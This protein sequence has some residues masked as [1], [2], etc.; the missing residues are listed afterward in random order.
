MGNGFV[1]LLQNYNDQQTTVDNN[2]Q[3]SWIHW[4]CVS[5]ENKHNKTEPLVFL[6]VFIFLG[7]LTGILRQKI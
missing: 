1:L 7:R 5:S 4:G 3:C 2:T 6:C